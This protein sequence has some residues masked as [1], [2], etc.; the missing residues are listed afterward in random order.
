ME[1]GTLA[2]FLKSSIYIRGLVNFQS[3]YENN[4]PFSCVKTIFPNYV[5]I[6]CD[7]HLR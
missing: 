5:M 3:N 1:K 2:V 7:I 4:I 6:Q